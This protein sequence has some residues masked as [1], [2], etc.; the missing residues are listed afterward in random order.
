MGINQQDQTSTLGQ[1]GWKGSGDESREQAGFQDKAQG[2]SVAKG[3]QAGRTVGGFFG[4]GAPVEAVGDLA[5]KSMTPDAQRSYNATMASRPSTATSITKTAGKMAGLP[6]Q[7]VNM[8][9]NMVDLAAMDAYTSSFNPDAPAQSRR[10]NAISAFS[11]N[12]SSGSQYL[13]L[14]HI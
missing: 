2:E 9:A 4:L 7:P 5:A 10:N 1:V 13:S 11:G 3:V 14:I 6:A 12:G 8:M